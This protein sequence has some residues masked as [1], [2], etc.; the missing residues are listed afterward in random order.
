LL[1]IILAYPASSASVVANLS[2]V[3]LNPSAIFIEGNY[4]AVFG[5][6]VDTNYAYLGPPIIPVATFTT[7]VQLRPIS[8]N[9]ITY[10]WIKIY[11]VSNRARPILIKDCKIQGSY[12]DGRKLLNGYVYLIS[13]N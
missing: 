7:M 1:S 8:L 6:Q 12:F 4:L 9:V 11:D 2:F 10:T 13:K 3:N 5:T